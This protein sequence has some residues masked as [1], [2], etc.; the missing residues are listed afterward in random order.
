MKTLNQL[1]NVLLCELKKGLCHDIDKYSQINNEKL[2]CW[3]LHNILSIHYE[4]FE[5]FT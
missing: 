4:V 2:N 1:K 3:A 5:F